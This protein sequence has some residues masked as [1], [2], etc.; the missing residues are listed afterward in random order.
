MGVAFPSWERWRDD[1]YGNIL[2]SAR[3]AHTLGETASV[4]LPS[5]SVIPPG[6]DKLPAR[7]IA[8][9]Q[10]GGDA[11]QVYPVRFNALV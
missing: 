4:R 5:L 7:A 3:L 2:L 6:C 9:V 11:P 8:V 10:R 1:G